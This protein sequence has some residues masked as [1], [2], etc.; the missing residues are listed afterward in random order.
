MGRWELPAGRPEA[1]EDWRT[2]LDREVMEEACAKV[3]SA[4]LLGFGRGECVRGTE[5]G[6]VLV[7]A[8]WRADVELLPWEPVHEMKYRQQVAPAAALAQMAIPVGLVPLN[9]HL[10]EEAL[11]IA[12]D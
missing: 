3:V 4:S 8:F 7:R 9:Q 12:R 5:Q 10:I 1:G 11:A 2:T 6:L